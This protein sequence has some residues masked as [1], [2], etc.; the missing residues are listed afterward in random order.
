MAVATDIG[1]PAD[2]HPG[3]KQDVGIRLAAIA[4]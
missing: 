3:D 2:I 1:N 4:L